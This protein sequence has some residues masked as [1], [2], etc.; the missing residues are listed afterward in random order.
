MANAS[1]EDART[2]EAVARHMV[3]SEPSAVSAQVGL[4]ALAHL[5]DMMPAKE[6]LQFINDAIQ[7]AQAPPAGDQEAQ[8]PGAGQPQQ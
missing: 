6:F 4:H 5:A 2:N 8:Q 3:Q 1:P 7:Q